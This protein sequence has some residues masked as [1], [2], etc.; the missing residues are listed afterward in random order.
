MRES[1]FDRLRIRSSVRCGYLLLA[2]GGASVATAAEWSGYLGAEVRA[3]EES[4]EHVGQDNGGLATIVFEPEFYAEWEDGYQS[5]EFSPYFRWD[6]Q[7]DERSL[8]DIRELSY[9]KVAGDWEFRVGISK[10]FWG[11]AESQHLV[12]VVNQTDLVASLDG[13]EKL[14]QAMVQVVNISRWGDFSLFVLPG[15][16]ERTFPGEEGRLR[17]GIVVDSDRSLY[18]SGEGKDHVDVALRW[19]KILGDFDVGVHYFRGTRRDPL[20]E[21]QVDGGETSLV[22]YYEQMDQLGLDLQ[23]TKEGWLLKLEAIA[24][25]ASSEDYS[26]A[27][28]GFEYTFYGIFGSSIDA[29]LLVEGH[30]D[31]RG[32]DATT[33]FNNDIFVGTRL[34]W[35]D[36]ADTS[37]VAGVFRDWKN[38][39]MVGLVEFERRLRGS[40]KLEIE[41]QKMG[42]I[43][44]QDALYPVRRDSYAQIGLKRHF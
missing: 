27:V 21:L 30:L 28:A 40:M 29:G 4:P 36:E 3:Y 22:P 41:V 16:R 14:G 44:P 24:R 15:F 9:L 19:F 17:G 33:S 23:Y 31:E 37:L 6:S 32:E 18:E 8:I 12:D 26:A 20:F 39:S 34:G 11:V 2:L 35:N 43:D 42:S 5:I 10:V 13:E 7:D 38:D 1:L 25:D